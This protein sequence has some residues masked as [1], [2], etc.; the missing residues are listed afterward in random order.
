MDLLANN[1]AAL[2]HVERLIRTINAGA[3][4]HHTTHSTID[5][6]HVLGKGLYSSTGINATGTIDCIE[7]NT[8]ATVPL[9]LTNSTPPTCPTCDATPHDHNHHDHAHD[10]HHQCTVHDVGVQTVNVVCAGQLDEDRL[11]RFVEGLLWEGRIYPTEY[12]SHPGATLEHDDVATL[13]RG[14]G[15]TL[16]HDDVATL[17]RGDGQQERAVVF[18]IKGMVTLKDKGTVGD[19]TGAP[20]RCMLQV[21]CYTLC[22]GSSIVVIIIIIIIVISYYYCGCTTD[23]TICFCFVAPSS[24]FLHFILHSFVRHATPMHFP[25]PS[26][27]V[28]MSCMSC[29][30]ALHGALGRISG[31]GFSLWGLACMQVRCNKLW[32]HVW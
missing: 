11:R 28:C 4:I 6:A 32:K 21:C 10:A 17:E 1:T 26:H 3:T 9:F 2:A 12:T 30:A 23:I 19:N 29:T 18:R 13:E 25:H 20:R 27:R 8:G 15:D 7:T 31:P 22:W 5:L 24:V 16:E 14:D